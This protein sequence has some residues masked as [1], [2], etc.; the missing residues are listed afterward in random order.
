MT[1]R[2]RH[3]FILEIQLATE[4]I[5]LQ[6]TIVEENTSLFN[7]TFYLVVA[8]RPKEMSSL[9]SEQTKFRVSTS[10]TKIEF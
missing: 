7:S 9:G 1:K 2:P 8:S 10:S 3:K 5:T 6:E 4:R